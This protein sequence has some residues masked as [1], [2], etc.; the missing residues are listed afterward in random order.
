MKDTLTVRFF[1]LPF[2]KRGDLE[3][4]TLPDANYYENTPVGLVAK[5]AERAGFNVRIHD[6]PGCGTSCSCRSC[7][8]KYHGGW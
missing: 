3:M 7:Q 6:S 4:T 2:E 5:L 1:P 8:M